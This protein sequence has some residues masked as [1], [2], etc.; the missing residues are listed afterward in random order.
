MR[1]LEQLKEHYQIE[2]ELAGQLRKASAADRPK[3]YSSLYNELFQRFPELVH[4]DPDSANKRL[5]KDLRTIRKW[6]DQETVFLEIGP[7]DCKMA[8]EV[9]GSVKKVIAIDVSSEITKQIEMPDNFSLILSDGSSIPVP[10][11]SVN[12]AYSN[13]LMEHLHP[14][15]AVKQLK[16]IFR[17]LVPGGFYLCLTPNR[18]SGPHDI[19]MYFDEVATGF[20][21]REYT[22]IELVDLFK[23]AGFSDMVVY[24]GLNGYDIACPLFLVKIL[25]AVMAR[26]PHSLRKKA[27]GTLLNNIFISGKKC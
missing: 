5:K 23:K 11:N 19:S 25:E 7:G 26:L 14:E 6:L 10:E 21:L 17:A 18:L 8:I 20:H 2:R 1:T 13:Q 27:R 12:I 4:S 9:A 3:L 16:N 22:N 15:D 24:M